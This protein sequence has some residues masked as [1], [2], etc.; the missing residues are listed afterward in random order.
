[1]VV[2]SMSMYLLLSATY[3]R[4]TLSKQLSLPS[5]STAL[6]STNLILGYEKKPKKAPAAS[7]HCWESA[8]G[9]RPKVNRPSQCGNPSFSYWLSRPRFPKHFGG[10]FW[11]QLDG[12]MFPLETKSYKLAEPMIM[13]KH[14]RSMVV[15]QGC[16]EWRKPV[17][18][19]L[20]TTGHCESWLEVEMG[21]RNTIG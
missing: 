20:L 1:M 21:P 12:S 17:W 15:H 13:E 4:F 7:H 14:R 8:A 3:V 10:N 5:R 19:C 2:D 16:S 6:S 11:F 18:Q 9:S